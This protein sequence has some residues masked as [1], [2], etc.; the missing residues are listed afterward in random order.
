MNMFLNN[1]QN[2]LRRRRKNKGGRVETSKLIKLH[3]QQQNMLSVSFFFYF[4]SD[5][6]AKHK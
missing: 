1:K 4:L 5:K 6:L 3:N 2:K